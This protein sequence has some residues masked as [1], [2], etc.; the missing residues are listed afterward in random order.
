MRKK[1]AF[2]DLTNLTKIKSSFN[3]YFGFWST[4]TDSNADKI[5]EDLKLSKT[6]QNQLGMD[7]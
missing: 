1:N 4:A 3:I 5:P 6:P 7:A 2:C